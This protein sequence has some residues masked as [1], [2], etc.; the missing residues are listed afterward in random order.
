MK[1]RLCR[2]FGWVLIIGLSASLIAAAPAQQ[3]MRI[4]YNEVVQGEITDSNSEQNWEFDGHTGDLI[5]IDLR[6]DGS[7]LDPYLTLLDPFGN[8]L[9]NDDDS[10]EGLNSRIGP[11]PLPGDGIYTI[12][13]GRYG[14]LGAYSLELKNLSTIPALAPGKPLVGVVE[15]DHTTDYFIL[16]VGDSDTLWRLEISDDQSYS[17]PYLAVYGAGGLLN[18]TESSGGGVIE[19]IVAVPGERYVA[20]VSWNVDSVGG[21]YELELVESDV[22][23]LGATPQSE[24]LDYDVTEQE[25]YFRGEADQTVRL[26]AAVEGDV[27]LAL[28]ISSIGGTILF[29]ASG[30]ATT[31]LTAALVLPETGVYRVRVWDGSYMGGTGTY[32]ISLETAP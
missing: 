26:S 25:H 7:D 12:V 15:A 19:P 2:A 9:L 6:A 5:L 29:S 23:L 32:T 22:T 1:T 14:G 8:P 3:G 18:T 27:T 20:V 31:E 11:L 24:T 16:D 21:P 17:D 10:G 30:E 13:A 4:Q 28:E